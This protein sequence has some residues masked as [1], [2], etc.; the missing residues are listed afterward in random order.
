MHRDKIALFRTKVKWD[1]S[2][3]R[4]TAISQVGNPRRQS[5]SR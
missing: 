5:V 4:T 3:V 2:I 1:C